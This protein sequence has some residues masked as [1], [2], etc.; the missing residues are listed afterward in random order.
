MKKIIL[1]NPLIHEFA[2]FQ[3]F[4][5]ITVDAS[6]LPNF[7]RTFPKGAKRAITL[8]KSKF[9]EK[10]RKA[11]LDNHLIHVFAMFYLFISITV[12][13]SPVPNYKKTFQKDSKR[14]I[15]LKIIKI[16]KKV[17]LEQSL[18]KR[19][20]HLSVWNLNNCRC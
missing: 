5:S 6:P 14:A 18:S 12:E 10:W 1:D 20:C 7:N 4:N 2:Y 19:F 16:F 8:K 13:V 15:T 17:I 11:I 9:K 3:L